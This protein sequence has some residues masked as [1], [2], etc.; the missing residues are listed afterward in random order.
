MDDT[1]EVELYHPPCSMQEKRQL[2]QINKIDAIFQQ[3][4]D[5]SNE[6]RLQQQQQQL[7]QD[8]RQLR[9]DQRR[10]RGQSSSSS[11]L[12]PQ[13]SFSSGC[14]LH[15]SDIVRLFSQAAQR[16]HLHVESSIIEDAVDAL[17]DEVVAVRNDSNNNNNNNNTGGGTSDTIGKEMTSSSSFSSR[18]LFTKKQFRAL[19]LDHPDL[20]KCL[21]QQQQR[22]QH[23]YEEEEEV[24]GRGYHSSLS[25]S[26]QDGSSGMTEDT[27][28]ETSEQTSN[29]MLYVVDN[30]NG[31]YC[32]P[33]HDQPEST[34]RNSTVLISSGNYCRSAIS[35]LL[36]KCSSCSQKTR[37]SISTR[38]KNQQTALIWNFLYLAANLTCFLYKA[39]L[40]VHHRPETT[41]VFGNCIVVARGSAQCLN[42]NCAL[43]LLPVCR[44]LL[45]RLRISVHHHKYMRYIFPFDSIMHYHVFIGMSI[46]FFTILHVGA[47]VCD[48]HRFSIA[49]EQDL[50]DL[51]GNKFGTKIPDSPVDRWVMLFQTPVAITGIIMLL[52]M[53]IAYP[54]TR[55]RRS[56]FNTFWWSHQ[57]LLIMLVALCFHGMG[58]LVEP[59]QSVY[60]IMVPLACY[61]VPRLLRETPRS[62][63]DVL[64]VTVQKGNVIRLRLAKPDSWTKSSSVLQAGMYAYLNIPQV[65]RLEWHPFTMTSAPS[66][67]YIEFHCRRTGDWTA[68]VHDLLREYAEAAMQS[69]TTPRTAIVTHSDIENGQGT[70]GNDDDAVDT[71]KIATKSL[72]YSDLVV[73]VEGPMGASSQGFSHYPIVVLV[74]AGIGVAPMMSVLKELLANPGKM[75]RVF[76]YWTVRDCASFAW[77]STLMQDIYYTHHHN[78]KT[79]KNHNVDDGQQQQQQQVMHIRHFL[80]SAQRPADKD[81]GAVLLQYAKRAKHNKTNFD[82]L[83]GQYSHHQADVGRPDWE[84]ELLSVKTQAKELG[85]GKC[86]VFLCGP[87]KMAKTVATQCFR[88]SKKDPDFHFY[89]S[90]EIF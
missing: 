74:G 87:D 46:L 52:C 30:N 85:H 33:S 56:H 23:D 2:Q 80:T 58:S 21:E 9:Q 60:W 41:H 4:L 77:F 76:L 7:L 50:V 8:E 78:R 44:H 18:L 71:S 27:T 55:I 10:Q 70:G 22:Q 75:K 19:F 1:V 73:K 54:L 62:N 12:R 66:D 38:W 11:L 28:L 88:L 86:G 64:S 83:L 57:L 59:F 47:H 25:Q 48:F 51:F 6:L 89:F 49:P 15:R 17:L 14:C 13:N 82:L 43:I 39:L 24:G 72:S 45:T 67:S 20:I 81:I 79:T 29:T 5:E 3:L 42:L 26:L 36:A 53:I 16:M 68:K 40:Y 69:T 63:C 37:S 31:Q 35:L 34:T 90:K 61:L 84:T 65:S 32:F